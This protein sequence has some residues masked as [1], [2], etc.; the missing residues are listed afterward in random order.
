MIRKGKLE[1]HNPSY[2]KKGACPE[3]GQQ[4]TSLMKSR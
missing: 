4:S 2:H 1:S 3:E